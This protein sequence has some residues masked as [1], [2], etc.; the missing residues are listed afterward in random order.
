MVSARAP[1]RRS[2]T[3]NVPLPPGPRAPTTVNS[4]RHLRRPLETLL[5]WQRHY[6]DVFTVR[7]LIFGTGR[8]SLR[9]AAPAIRLATPR[10]NCTNA[11]L[12]AVS[13][14]S[15]VRRCGSERPHRTGAR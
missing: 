1:V 11:L 15:R 12:P 14:T 7:Y 3:R 5:G 9:S 2:Y 4:E 8:R 13:I 6:G 10:V